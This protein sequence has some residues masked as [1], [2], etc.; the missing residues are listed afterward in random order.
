MSAE[1]L[2]VADAADDERRTRA[3]E[4]FRYAEADLLDQ[5]R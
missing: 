2:A 4:R 3:A 1:P 5:W